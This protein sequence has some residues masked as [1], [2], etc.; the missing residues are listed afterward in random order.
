MT[1]QPKRVSHLSERAKDC[2]RGPVCGAEKPWLRYNRKVFSKPGRQAPRLQDTAFAPPVS[3]TFH[4]PLRRLRAIKTAAQGA[5]AGSLR[6]ANGRLHCG[7][8]VVARRVRAAFSA[9]ILRGLITGRSLGRHTG[10]RTWRTHPQPNIS[11]KAS[12][13]MGESFVRATGRSGWRA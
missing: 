9:A 3:R 13:R 5:L 1:S 6:Q 8:R 7:I 10:F 12:R 11:F 4:V 2:S